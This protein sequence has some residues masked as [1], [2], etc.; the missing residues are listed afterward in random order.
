M[1]QWSIQGCP[2][3]NYELNS[4]N[5]HE[6]GHAMKAVVL[7][8]VIFATIVLRSTGRYDDAE[9]LSRYIHESFT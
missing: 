6:T 4:W 7:L 1:P 8:T 5:Q 9:I 2:L 3:G